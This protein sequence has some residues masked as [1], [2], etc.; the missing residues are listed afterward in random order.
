MQTI[1]RI[2]LALFGLKGFTLRIINKGKDGH[3]TK[4]GRQLINMEKIYY[5]DTCDKCIAKI[6]KKIN[7]NKDINELFCQK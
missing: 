7:K 4:C 1:Y 3:C 5:L 2:L 6:I